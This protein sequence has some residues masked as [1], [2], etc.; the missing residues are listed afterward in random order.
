MLPNRCKCDNG[1]AAHSSF[2]SMEYICGLTSV[3]VDED[4]QTSRS[5]VDLARSSRIYNGAKTNSTTWP[6]YVQIFKTAPDKLPDC[7]GAILH[8]LYVI[9]AAHCMFIESQFESGKKRTLLS[10]VWVNTGS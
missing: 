5:R 6:F 2:K 8:P 1:I 10:R 9:T 3:K 4:Q 7:G